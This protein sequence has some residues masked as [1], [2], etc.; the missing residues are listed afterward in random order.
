MK[1]VLFLA[2]FLATVA[3]EASANDLVGSDRSAIDNVSKGKRDCEG[4]LMLSSTKEDEDSFRVVLGGGKNPR[5]K[6]PNL[7]K[8]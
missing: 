5:L 4:T 8:R 2:L 1:F 6:Y 7:I 3:V